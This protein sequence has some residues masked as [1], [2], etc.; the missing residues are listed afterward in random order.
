MVACVSD[1]S[2]FTLSSWTCASVRWGGLVVP[3]C[4]S[5]GFSTVWEG[6]D[7]DEVHHNLL[8][9]LPTCH[10]FGGEEGGADR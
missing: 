2:S 1:A 6:F 4:V 7:V 5:E 9:K 8:A 10:T 3:V